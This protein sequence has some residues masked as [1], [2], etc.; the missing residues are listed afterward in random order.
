MRHDP[1]RVALLLV[2]C[3]L[4]GCARPRPAPPTAAAPPWTVAASSGIPNLDLV[5]GDIKE[6]RSSGRW[7]ADI[8]RVAEECAAAARDA[9]AQ[10][11][12]P[13]AVFDIDET[14]LSNWPYEM[15]HD[16]ARIASLFRDWAERSACPAIEPV[17]RFYVALHD[18]GIACFV[19]TGRRETLRDATIR[20][21][22]RQGI[23]GWTGI[24]FRPN[25]DRDTSVIP[26]KS[27]ER[28]RIESKGFTIITNIGDQDSDL[29]GGH[30][31][32]TCKLPNPMYFIP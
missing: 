9:H 7:E 27:G 29:A 4:L 14:L 21:L 10:G 1:R 23:S 19:I 24:S 31:L 3:A 25:D 17:K 15:E 12:R 28:A 11:R 18:A 5:K 13:A 2:V 26:F 6:Y 30:A 8:A 20:N 16:F 32:H 22:E